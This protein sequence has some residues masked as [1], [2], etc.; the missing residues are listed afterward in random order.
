LDNPATMALWAAML[1]IMCLLGIATW[2]AWLSI[3]VPLAGHASWH[4]YKDL[5]REQ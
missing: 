2:M 4:A 5:V 3:V 1:M